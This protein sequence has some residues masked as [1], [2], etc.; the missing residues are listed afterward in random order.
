MRQWAI[1]LGVF[2]L[3]GLLV[4]AIFGPHRP[5]D[6]QIA[7]AK[8]AHTEAQTAAAQ[9][10]ADLVRSFL[11][12][13]D[14]TDVDCA[15]GRIQVRPMTWTLLNA[16]A[17]EKLTELVAGYCEDVSQSM[18]VNLIDAQSGRELASFNASGYAVK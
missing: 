16:T 12:D 11:R 13:G 4:G 5:V 17:K 9:T 7:A 6:P 18:F 3:G 2:G 15:R 8:R 14:L 1:G 10:R